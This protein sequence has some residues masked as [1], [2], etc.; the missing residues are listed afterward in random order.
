MNLGSVSKTKKILITF[1]GIF[2]LSALAITLYQVQRSQDNRQRASGTAQI[3]ID[4]KNPTATEVITFPQ[5]G[6]AGWSNTQNVLAKDGQNSRTTFSGSG[7]SKTLIAKGFGFAVPQNSIIKGVKVELTVKSS[8]INPNPKI[9]FVKLAKKTGT[10]TTLF[11]SPKGEGASTGSLQTHIFGGET[12]TWGGILTAAEV[13]SPDFGLGIRAKTTISGAST[14]EIDHVNITIY[15]SPTANLF[16]RYYCGQDQLLNISQLDPSIVKVTA[17]SPNADDKEELTLPQAEDYSWDRNNN[18]TQNALTAL[19]PGEYYVFETNN[20]V[21]SFNHPNLCEKYQLRATP[22]SQN[23]KLPTRLYNIAGSVTGS[24][25]CG[26]A[27]SSQN[28]STVL[29]QD[30]RGVFQFKDGKGFDYWFRSNPQIATLQSLEP[31]NHYYFTSVNGVVID[32]P[33]GN[34]CKPFI[35]RPIACQNFGD[36]D[37]DGKVSEFD[38]ADLRRIILGMGSYTPDQINRADVNSTPSTT[39]STVTA[40]DMVLMNYYVYGFIDTITACTTPQP[41]ACDDLGDI[42]GDGSLTLNDAVGVK[43]MALNLSTTYTD[44]QKTRANVAGG[45]GVDLADYDAINAYVKDQIQSLPACTTSTPTATPTAT[46][47][48]SQSTVSIKAPTTITQTSISIEGTMTKSAG[49]TLQSHFR[50]SKTNGACNSLG[51]VTPSRTLTTSQTSGSQSRAISGLTPN[52]TYYICMEGIPSSGEKVYSSVISFTT[53][54]AAS[55]STPTPT[56]T[57]APTVC[58]PNPSGE[59]GAIDGT[60]LAVAREE[61][62]GIRTTK[63]ASC[64][65]TPATDD[66]TGIDVAKIRH[67]ILGIPYE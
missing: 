49:Y 9:D 1:F 40:A 25:W 8:S 30:V 65:T 20:F 29:P 39:G 27:V 66:T 57:P 3:I 67:S 19:I 32:M 12:D 33:G 10:E 52:S 54:A 48:P 5:D 55:T 23:F 64:M 2:I 17:K 28:F 15:Y 18:V 34:H 44:D 26:A 37:G 42:T 21:D 59:A 63:L 53:L 46:P 24:P 4:T 60:D 6:Q 51:S 31:G 61:V 35:E 16:G 14:V 38:N 62:V 41:L 58:D 50:Y 7:T 45:T 22:L 47:V 13:N 11:S 43:R 56:H 36:I